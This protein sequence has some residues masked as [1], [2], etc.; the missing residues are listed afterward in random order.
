[1]DE[2]LG[3]IVEITSSLVVVDPL[4]GRKIVSTCWF[5]SALFGMAAG[6][7]L[8][9]GDNFGGVV[10]NLSVMMFLV[11]LPL[12][13]YALVIALARSARG[14]DIAVA[15]LF[16]LQNSAPASLRRSFLLSLGV[17]VV[18]AATT[19]FVNPFA[20][21]VPMLPLGLSGVWGARHG[22]YPPRPARRG[23]VPVGRGS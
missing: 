19:A 4:S 5:S 15:S 11:S 20:V 12:W 1:M 6:L 21:L 7:D 18:V 16:F 22:V 17:T 9:G 2:S 23:S 8:L 3:W 13:I 14:D 10:V